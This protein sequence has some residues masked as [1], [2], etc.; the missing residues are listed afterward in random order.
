VDET[1][2]PCRFCFE[3]IKAGAFACPYCTRAQSG[4]I[5]GTLPVSDRSARLGIAVVMVLLIGQLIATIW[6]IATN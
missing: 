4:D 6:L 1:T 2:Q 3:A 5:A